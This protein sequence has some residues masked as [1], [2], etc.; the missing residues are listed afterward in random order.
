MGIGLGIYGAHGV[1]QGM[2]WGKQV[3][4]YPGIQTG[5]GDKDGDGVGYSWLRTGVY[6]GRTLGVLDDV[7]DTAVNQWF[8]RIALIFTDGLTATGACLLLTKD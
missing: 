2:W 5:A 7:A 3:G 6:E 4:I 1:M 8:Y